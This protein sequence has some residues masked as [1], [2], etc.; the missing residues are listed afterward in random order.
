MI[1]VD[2]SAALIANELPSSPRDTR[3]MPR[4]GNRFVGTYLCSQGE[5]KLTIVIDEVGHDGDDLP[6]EARFEFLF[7]RPRGQGDDVR[8]AYRMSGRYDMK[9]RRLALK[10]GDWIGPPPANYVPVDIRGSL[11]K[12]GDTYNGTIDTKGCTTFDTK[13]DPATAGH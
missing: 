8:G 7:E 10:G 2:A 4:A 11:G 5:T 3:P 12:S 9:T 1:S 6:V 13:L